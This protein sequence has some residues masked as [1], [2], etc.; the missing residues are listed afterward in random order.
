[1]SETPEQRK[2]RLFSYA[3]KAMD[4]EQAAYKGFSGSDRAEAERH[5]LA[6]W[7]YCQVAEGA[8][9]EATLEQVRQDWH[10]HCQAMAVKVKASPKIRSGPMSGHY[11]AHYL[12]CG[13]GTIESDII[14]IRHMIG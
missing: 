7:A 13:T 1:M 11:S 6:R 5:R 8:D 10:K 4:R 14:H 2:E 3:R 9:V 12:H